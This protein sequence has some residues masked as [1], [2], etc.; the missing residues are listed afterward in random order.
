MVDGRKKA[1][2]LQADKKELDKIKRLEKQVA[3]LKQ[4]NELLKKWQRFLAEEHL[5]DISS[6]RETGKDSK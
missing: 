4:E 2:S 1:P 3:E 5:S 6:S